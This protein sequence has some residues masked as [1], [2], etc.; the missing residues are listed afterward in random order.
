MKHKFLG[1]VVAAA[2]MSTT[3][4]AEGTMLD[5]FE[6]MEKE[7][8]A[9]KAEIATMKAQSSAPVTAKKVVV[10]DDDEDV[11]PVKAKTGKV[12][13]AVPACRQPR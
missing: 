13:I 6:A 8:N 7:M 12:K 3:M 5:R 1:S 4:M 9:L 10:K 2:L 11:K